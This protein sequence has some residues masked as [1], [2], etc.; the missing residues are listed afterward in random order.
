MGVF[1]LLLPRPLSVHVENPGEL[2]ANSF[3]GGCHPRLANGKGTLFSGLH[4]LRS[5]KQ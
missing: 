4:A 5:K 2:S 1:L 3:G